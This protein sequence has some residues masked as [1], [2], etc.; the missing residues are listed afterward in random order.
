MCGI[1]ENCLQNFDQKTERKI[2]LGRPGYRS[3]DNMKLI[4]MCGGLVWIQTGS[5]EHGGEFFF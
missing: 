1:D 5:C 2:P 3:E 4:L